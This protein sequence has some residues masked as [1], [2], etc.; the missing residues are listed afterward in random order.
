MNNP[1][2]GQLSDNME[3]AVHSINSIS[4]IPVFPNKNSRS[5][6]KDPKAL[7]TDFDNIE[8]RSAGDHTAALEAHSPILSTSLDPNGMENKSAT[9]RNIQ[10]SADKIKDLKT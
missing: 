3:E 6:P 4:R 9:E 2:E 7:D 8:T 1:D 10:D 5:G